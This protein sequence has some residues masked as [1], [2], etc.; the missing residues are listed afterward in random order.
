[1]L[2]EGEKLAHEA[3]VFNL[4]EENYYRFWEDLNSELLTDKI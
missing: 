4:T 2:E 1:M 3:G